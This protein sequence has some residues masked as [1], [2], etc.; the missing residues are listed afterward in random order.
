[1]NTADGRHIHLTLAAGVLHSRATPP[2][3]LLAMEIV[4][5]DAI[6]CEK[7]HIDTI[8]DI[9]DDEC[10]DCMS[11]MSVIINDDL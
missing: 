3:G 2:S 1:M 10:P 6:E 8:T 9:A 4:E 11:V 7:V 5:E